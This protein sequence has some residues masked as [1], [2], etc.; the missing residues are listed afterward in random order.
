MVYTFNVK[1]RKGFYLQC[2]QRSQTINRHLVHMRD[3]I[4]ATTSGYAN[5]ILRVNRKLS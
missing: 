1:F 5:K 3:L 2:F 4:V